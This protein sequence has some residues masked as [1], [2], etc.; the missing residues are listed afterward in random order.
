MCPEI[1]LP[2]S[3]A[4]NIQNT[5]I[6]QRKLDPGREHITKRR[7][8]SFEKEQRGHSFSVLVPDLAEGH[9]ED[10]GDERDE[11]RIV[12]A[13]DAVVKPLA[14]VVEFADTF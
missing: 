13:A 7:W 10:G 1:D 6:F 4:S 9:G 3:C 8:K 11:L 5:H 14:V 12:L 2:L